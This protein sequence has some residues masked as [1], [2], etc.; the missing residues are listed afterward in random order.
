MFQFCIM[1]AIPRSL[2]LSKS[3]MQANIQT[4]GHNKKTRTFTVMDNI[5]YF[6]VI[7]NVWRRNFRISSIV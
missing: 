3:C 5:N 6:G 4:Y 7:L 2:C 1:D